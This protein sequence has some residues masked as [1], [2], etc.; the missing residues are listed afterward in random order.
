MRL[1][2][3]LLI[4]KL[5]QGQKGLIA[6]VFLKK[7]PEEVIFDNK[8]EIKVGLLGEENSGKSTLVW[9]ENNI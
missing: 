2:A 6:E 1:K 3:I 8:E 5:F 9:Y 4:N 7:P